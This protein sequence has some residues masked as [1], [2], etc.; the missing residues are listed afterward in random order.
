M[1]DIF[2]IASMQ[3]QP[4]SWKRTSS[5]FFECKESELAATTTSL[6]AIVHARVFKAGLTPRIFASILFLKVHE[7]S[8]TFNG[9]PTYEGF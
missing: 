5:C 7:D 2:H 8:Y 3:L 1:L 4:N 6:E 9:R